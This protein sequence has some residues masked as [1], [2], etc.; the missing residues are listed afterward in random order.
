[1]VGI[2]TLVDAH[3]TIVT[4]SKVFRATY[5]AETTLG[6]MIRLFVVGHPQVAYV[7]MIFTKSHP[8]ANT[9]IA[10]KIKTNHQ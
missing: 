4:V 5:T 6:A 8:T 2:K 10:E 3:A 1:M 7:T 9:V